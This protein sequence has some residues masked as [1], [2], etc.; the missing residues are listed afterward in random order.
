[1]ILYCPCVCAGRPWWV[2][3]IQQAG[4]GG[5]LTVDYPGPGLFT[6]SWRAPVTGP[7]VAFTISPPAPV[8]TGDT[9]LE[10]ED[11]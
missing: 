4:G 1:M 7:V 9:Y 8:Q 6:T 2:E 10:E 5:K 3:D 11:N